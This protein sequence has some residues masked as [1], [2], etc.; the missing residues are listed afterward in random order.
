MFSNQFAMASSISGLLVLGAGGIG[1][2]IAR[3]L[4]AGRLVFLAD[5]LLKIPYSAAS[6]L[7]SDGHEVE[8]QIVDV[9]SNDSV[10]NLVKV[11]SGTARLNT[12]VNPDL[13][14]QSLSWFSRIS[15]ADDKA[16]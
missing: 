12:V 2:A 13:A 7:R 14:I 1:L 8:T 9:L 3:R 15:Y 5:N 6:S 11:A 4:G 16:S 10:K